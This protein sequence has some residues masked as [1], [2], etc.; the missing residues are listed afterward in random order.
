M[1]RSSVRSLSPTAALLGRLAAARRNRFSPF[2]FAAIVIMWSLAAPC[3]AQLTCET[4]QQV[5]LG[6]VPFATALSFSDHVSA[7]GGCG[8]AVVHHAA[9]FRFTASSPGW[10]SVCA[11]IPAAANQQWSPSISLLDGCGGPE[12]STRF[13][14]GSYFP[15]SGQGCGGGLRTYE[16]SVFRMEAGQSR[17]IIVG[18]ATENDFGQ[19]DLRLDF[20]GA[21]QMAGAQ[22][23]QLG[24]N[25]FVVAA[26][27]PALRSGVCDIMPN[28][29]RFSFTP[30]ETGTYRLSF[31]DGLWPYWRA[32]LDPD[33]QQPLD[34]AVYCNNGREF[35][36]AF[37][38]G[39]TYY[40]APGT[41][42]NSQGCAI[43]RVFVWHIRPCPPDYNKDGRVDGMDLSILLVGWGTA[44]S[45]ITG[46]ETTNGA[47]LSLLLA[48]W[49]D[50]PT[51]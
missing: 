17:V 18:G 47:D 19:G 28:A 48:L 43:R 34:G 31:C 51:R 27:S 15:T 36:G 24:T 11:I 37:E 23:L 30:A 44:G 41:Q 38:A 7:A 14:G 45:D 21:T 32:A 10:Y 2:A 5:S 9:Y 20:V 35:T 13:R 6:T 1:Q 8:G 29:Q 40:F 26:F 39:Q 12:D 16:T 4:A 22:Q 25:S 49:G 3:R 50:C 46:D 42:W 33:L